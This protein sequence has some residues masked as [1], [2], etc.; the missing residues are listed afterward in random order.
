[1]GVLIYAV[2]FTVLKSEVIVGQPLFNRHLERLY[3]IS[4]LALTRNVRH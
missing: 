2:V 4:A 3:T 1:M